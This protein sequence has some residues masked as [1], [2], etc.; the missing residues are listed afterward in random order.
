MREVVTWKQRRVRP[1]TSDASCRFPRCTRPVVKSSFLGGFET[2]CGCC[3]VELPRVL[4]AQSENRM[5][6]VSVVLTVVAFLLFLGSLFSSCFL[7]RLFITAK[8]QHACVFVC[9]RCQDPSTIQFASP[10]C[11]RL[12]SPRANILLFCASVKPLQICALPF[13]QPAI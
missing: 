10:D 9:M 11:P 8:L 7:G 2:E 6:G 1:R 4:Q 12:C 5:F 13:H 3:A